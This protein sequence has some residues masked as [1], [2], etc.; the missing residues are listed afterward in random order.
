MLLIMAKA[1]FKPISFSTTMRNPGRIAGFL[2]CLLAYEGKVLDNDII[3]DIIKEVIGRKLYKPT[4]VDAILDLKDTYNSES[5]T[6]SETQLDY[7]YK[8]SNQDHKE[9]GFDKGWPSRFDTFYKLPKEFGFIQYSI[10]A[11]IKISVVGHMLINAYKE[12]PINESMIQD[13]FLNALMKYPVNNPYRKILNDNVPLVLLMQ[14]L[15]LLKGKYPKGAGLSRQELS[16]LICWPNHDA[17]AVVDFIV[18]FRKSYP[19][20]SYSDEVIYLNCLTL[21]NAT[22]EQSRYYKMNKIIG[23]AVDEYIRKM[24]STGVISLRGNGRFIDINSLEN[25]KI[26]YI[27]KTYSKPKRF[28]SFDEYMDYMG[29]IDDN[30]ISI[31]RVEDDERDNSIKIE[32]LKRYATSYTKEEIY[33]E[34]INVC[35]KKA[36]TDNLLKLIEGPTRL[37]FLTSIAL[38]QNFNNVSVVPNYVVDDEGLPIRHASGGK[39]DIVCFDAIYEGLFEVTLMIG[40]QQTFNEILPITRHLHEELDNRANVVAFFI[41]PVVFDDAKRMARFVKYDEGLD[42]IT[43]DIEDFIERL[44]VYHSLDEMVVQ[45]ISVA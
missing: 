20:F 5:E 24:R 23:E 10:G 18:R 16:F 14:V 19:S 11:P 30:I 40:R 4:I 12:E 7:I 6:F 44:K 13:I 25:D 41:A 21:M 8:N 37:E 22:I 42:V 32:A 9:A 1:K 34:L 43:Y 29:N 2:H 3:E 26:E 38:V 31:K 39:A 27:L 15:K 45:E 28:N 35:R 33:K 36:S 17:E